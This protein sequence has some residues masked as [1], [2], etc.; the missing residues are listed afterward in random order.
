MKVS[1]LVAILIFTAQAQAMT[2]H[3]LM[4]A[5]EAVAAAFLEK[6]G[7]NTKKE[8]GA[9][10]L[11][12]LSSADGSDIELGDYSI[13]VFACSKTAET[14]P[15][16]FYV[17]KIGNPTAPNPSCPMRIFLDSVRPKTPVP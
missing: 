3:C 10:S 12:E 9:C 17:A 14:D 5:W 15:N 6:T 16:Y 2:K 13:G 1:A 7:C 8:C 11:E 4:D